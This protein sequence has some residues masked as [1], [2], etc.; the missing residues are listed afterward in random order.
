VLPARMTFVLE[1]RND[2]WLIV[3]AHFSPPAMGQEEGA[4]V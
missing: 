2:D 1:S 3:H 4:S